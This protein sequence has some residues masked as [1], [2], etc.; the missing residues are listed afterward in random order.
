MTR[1]IVVLCLVLAAWG[2]ATIGTHQGTA[3]A[4]GAGGGNANAC[5]QHIANNGNSYGYGLDCAASFTVSIIG[6]S[7]TFPGTCELQF[8]GSGLMPGV[9]VDEALASDPTTTFAISDLGGT[10]MTVPSTGVL[11]DQAIFLPGFTRIF[12]VQSAFGSTLTSGP[13]AITC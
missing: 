8:T 13:V 6:P 2:S 5:A 4:A 11:T 12:S 10:L 1:L 9:F 3:L 7:A